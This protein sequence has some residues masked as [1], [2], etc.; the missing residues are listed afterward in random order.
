VYKEARELL[1]AFF[2]EEQTEA[3]LIAS[4]LANGNAEVEFKI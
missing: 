2:D 4:Q 1:E 3:A